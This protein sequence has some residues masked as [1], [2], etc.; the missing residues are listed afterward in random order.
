MDNITSGIAPNTNE[1][2]LADLP[3][4]AYQTY[5]I[6]PESNGSYSSVLYPDEKLN[7]SMYL[8]EKGEIVDGD[9]LLGAL[10]VYLKNENLVSFRVS[11]V[12]NERSGASAIFLFN[13]TSVTRT[14][15]P[16]GD[17]AF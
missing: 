4:M 9:N 11:T 2:A 13:V 17:I 12:K 14:T 8:D 1:N 15:S 7:S 10:S 6:N 3:W 5:L 16:F